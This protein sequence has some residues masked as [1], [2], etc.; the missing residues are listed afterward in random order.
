MVSANAGTAACIRSTNRH[1]SPG[2][3][4]R[5]RM[6][7]FYL[8][9]IGPRP[10]A[11]FRHAVS[12]YTRRMK[13]LAVLV[14]ACLVAAPCLA[15]QERSPRETVEALNALRIDPSSIYTISPGNRIELERGDIRVA[16]EEGRLAFFAAFDGKLN[17]AVFSGK[18]HVLGAPRDVVE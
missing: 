18:G 8:F 5:R 9:A 11:L 12:D 3:V 7:S 17:G 10:R 14:L 13:V 16:F 6:N 1:K 2:V 15:A 4:K